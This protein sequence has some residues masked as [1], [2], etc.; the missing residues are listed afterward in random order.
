MSILHD[1]SID[2]SSVL[3]RINSFPFARVVQ[4]NHSAST[5]LNPSIATLENSLE[6]CSNVINCNRTSLNVAS[7]KKRFE[8]R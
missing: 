2:S 7:L 8:R 4:R 1:V 5:L 6:I 3:S